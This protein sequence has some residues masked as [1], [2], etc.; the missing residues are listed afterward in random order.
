MLFQNG[1]GAAAVFSLSQQGFQSLKDD[2]LLRAVVGNDG[3]GVLDRLAAS[4][5]WGMLIWLLLFITILS[6]AVFPESQAA[7]WR[8]QLFSFRNPGGTKADFCMRGLGRKG[9]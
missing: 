8:K 3:Q 1:V 9:M 2:R 4:G 5:A 7:I 6:F